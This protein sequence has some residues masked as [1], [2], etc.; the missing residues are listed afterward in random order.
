MKEQAE[1]ENLKAKVSVS[2]VRVAAA[3]AVLVLMAAFL[4]GVK[5]PNHN[6]TLT[7]V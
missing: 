7:R 5:L 6:E 4:G 3:S 2:C 1:G